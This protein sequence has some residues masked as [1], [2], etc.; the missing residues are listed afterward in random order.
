MDDSRIR[1]LEEQV[2]RQQKQ[3]TDL[4]VAVT[5]I[6]SALVGV[7]PDYVRPMFAA[8]LSEALEH[9]ERENA[10]SAA[11]VYRGVLKLMDTAPPFPRP[12]DADGG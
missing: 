9:A 2:K 4:G 10:P 8:C 5:M 3:L 12:R 1:Q 6:S 7:I 11:V